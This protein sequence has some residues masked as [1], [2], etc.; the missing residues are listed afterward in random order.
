MAVD[1]TQAFFDRLA[2]DAEL[3]AIIGSYQ[4][5]PKIFTARPPGAVGLPYVVIGGL[6]QET[7]ASTF[8]SVATDQ[9]RNIEVWFGPGNAEQMRV[10]GLRVLT[11]FDYPAPVLEMQDW[12]TDLQSA[13]GPFEGEAIEQA[14]SR[15]IQIRCQF[16]QEVAA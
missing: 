1:S 4:G 16:R 14:Q 13:T 6:V 5:A 15:I 11:L 12:V 3:V 10:A 7:D 2:G 8:S 9:T